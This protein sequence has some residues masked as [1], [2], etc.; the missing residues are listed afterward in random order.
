M[1]LGQA[2]IP[3]PPMLPQPKGSNA[4]SAAQPKQQTSPQAIPDL[5]LDQIKSLV[6]KACG[7]NAHNISV[8][9]LAA[10]RV[11]VTLSVPTENLAS[12][13]YDRV[14]SIPEFGPMVVCVKIQVEK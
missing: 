14:V 4:Q 10:N 2:K 12:V 13:M 3:V 6:Q 7:A 5:T 9:K 8:R 1:N 11:E